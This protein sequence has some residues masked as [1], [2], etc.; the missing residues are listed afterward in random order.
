M[1]R[2]VWQAS[3]VMISRVFIRWLCVFEV[4]WAG[5]FLEEGNER[6]LSGV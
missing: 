1:W 3:L 2:T 5:D 6:S 4:S